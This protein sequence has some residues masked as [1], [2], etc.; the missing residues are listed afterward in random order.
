MSENIND[1][2]LDKLL[3]INGKMNDS[4]ESGPIW[5]K[6]NFVVRSIKNL[7]LNMGVKIFYLQI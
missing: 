1:D 3:G 6:I 2:Q 4:F 7:V 5:T